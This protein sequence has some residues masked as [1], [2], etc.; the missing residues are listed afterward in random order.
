MGTTIRRRILTASIPA[1]LA[2]I[3]WGAWHLSGGAP[4][5]GEPAAGAAFQVDGNRI[6]HADREPQNWIAHGRDYAE[7]RFSPLSEINAKTVGDLGLA[8]HYDTGM[9]RGLEASPIVVGGMLFTTGNMGVVY[10]LDAKTGRE[11]W[12]FDPE[13]PG[14]WARYGCCDI[15][16]RGVAIWKGK[17]YVASFDGRLIALSAETGRKI[18]EVNTI[19]RAKPY[20][21]TAAPRIVK[22]KVIIGNG[23]AELGVR[24]YV[25]AYD[26]ESG[27][28]LWRFYTVPGD[29]AQP[30]EHPELKKAAKTWKGGKWWEIGGGGTVWD[31]IAYDPDLNLLYVGVGNG[32][33]WTRAIRSPGGGDNLYLSSILA[34]NADTGRLQWHYQTTPGDNWDYTATQHMILAQMEIDGQSR[35]VIMQAPKN[36]FFYVL[37]R[38]TGELLRADPYAKTITWASHVD[39]KTGR[40]VENTALAY[41]KQAQFIFPS[42]LGGHNWQPMAYSPQTG[43][44]YIPTIDLAGP[45]ILSGEW[46]RKGEYTPRQGWWNTGMDMGEYT[47]ALLALPEIPISRG[48]LK[49]WDP[50]KGEA[51]WT[52]EHP[53]FWNGGLLATAGGLV[54][55]GTGDGRF[56]AYDALSGEKLWETPVYAG[57]VAPPVTYRIDGQQYVAVMAGWGGAVLAAGDPRTAAAAQRENEGRLLVFKLGGEAILPPLAEKNQEIPEPPQELV[58]R[59]S[60]RGIDEGRALYSDFCLTCHGALVISSGVLPDLRRMSAATHEQFQEI[61]REGLLKENGMAGFGDL[62]TRRDTDKIHAYIASRAREDRRAMRALETPAAPLV[63]AVPGAPVAPAVPGAPEAPASEAPTDLP[64]ADLPVDLPPVDLP[65]AAPPEAELPEAAPLP[66]PRQDAPPPSRQDAPPPRQDAPRQDAAPP[67]EAVEP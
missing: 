26:A 43:L 36:G 11:I 56:V 46:K 13:V 3:L 8:W 29:P 48:Y 50:V 49:A 16:N 51:R 52:V 22:G 62:L 14:E 33:P 37:D 12:T 45:F 58:P 19:D 17:I 39:I 44:V 65:Q 7:R 61:V 21:I 67:L 59:V 18:W 34:L 1:L 15:V 42:A 10:A 55:Q 28:E 27:K 57:I 47:R 63:P 54:F 23:G 53:D 60:R 41:D 31:S 2:V 38:E 35:K 6:I 5:F 32:S 30:F 24:G 20:T 64:Q 4:L 9:R 66:P 40:P 25:S